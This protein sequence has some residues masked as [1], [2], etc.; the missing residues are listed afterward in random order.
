MASTPKLLNA[1]QLFPL[2]ALLVRV[3]SRELEGE[4]ARVAIGGLGRKHI[5]LLGLAESE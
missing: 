5:T 2:V 4:Y 1:Q 3:E